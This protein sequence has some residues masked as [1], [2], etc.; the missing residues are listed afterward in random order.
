MKTV[1]VTGTR[2]GLSPQQIKMLHDA[3]EWLRREDQGFSHFVHGGAEGADEQLHTLAVLLGYTIEVWPSNRPEKHQRWSKDPSV[4][5]C[6]EAYPPM[7][8]NRYIVDTAD[9]ML[10]APAVED[11][12]RPTY[13]SGTVHTIRIA[14]DQGKE[15]WVITPEGELTVIPEES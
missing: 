11:W 8:R 5:F 12:D 1:G 10:A 4:T 3:L 7:E 14:A 9:H 2:K 15:T 13:R 6:H